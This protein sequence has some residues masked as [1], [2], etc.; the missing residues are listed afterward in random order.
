MWKMRAVAGSH[1]A[2]RWVCEEVPRGENVKPLVYHMFT[3]M[4]S[5]GGIGLAANQLA[6]NKRIITVK[7]Q[8]FKHAI[9][10]PVITKTSSKTAIATEG[11]LSFVGQTERV[12]RFK[13]ITVEGFDEN[14]EP[15]KFKLKKLQARCVQHEIDHLNGIT[16]I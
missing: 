2:L 9:V 1:P 10:N 6:E 13:T 4:R 12:S 15:V 5:W 7:I 14:W 16:I 8:G 11:C 3:V